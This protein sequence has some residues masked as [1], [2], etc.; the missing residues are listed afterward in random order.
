MH[1]LEGQR[2]LEKG[3]GFMVR[4]N[5][6]TVFFCAC[7]LILKYGNNSWHLSGWFPKSASRCARGSMRKVSRKH[8]ARGSSCGSSG[9]SHETYGKSR[10]AV[11]GSIAE[12]TAKKIITEGS[13]EASFVGSADQMESSLRGSSAE[14]RGR[15][16]CY[17]KEIKKE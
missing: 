15:K 14:G 8:H 17:S 4:D 1:Y 2:D 12:A 3:L 5:S 6:A 10:N 16:G 11:R 9:R 7:L 13:V